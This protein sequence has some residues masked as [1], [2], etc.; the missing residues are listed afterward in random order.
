M[1]REV[2]IQEACEQSARYGRS[3]TDSLECDWKWALENKIDQFI[4]KADGRGKTDPTGEAGTEAVA[5]VKETLREHY[6][7]ILGIYD[8]YASLNADGDVFTIGMNEFNAFLNECELPI[9]GSLDCNKQHLEQL[10]VAIDSGQKAKE[11]FNSKHALS[12]QEFLQFLVRAAVSRYCKPRKKGEEPIHTDVSAALRELLLNQMKP[13]VDPAALQNSNEFRQKFLYVQETD[14]LLAQHE[15]TLQ[16][17]YDVYSDEQHAT[18]DL[19]S[20]SGMLGI[21]QWLNMCDHLQ[22]VDEEFTIREMTSC[23]MWARM[24]VADETN[25]VERRKMCNLKFVDFL[26]ALCRMA[27]MKTMPTDDEV[28][29]AGCADGG[30][31]LLK[32]VP[33]ERRNFVVQRPQNWDS[34]PRQPIWR[35]LFHLISLI[36]RSVEGVVTVKVKGVDPTVKADLRL[37]RAEVKTFKKLGGLAGAEQS[38]PGP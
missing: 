25:I 6:A 15:S 8:Y 12:R 29:A 1:D 22:L 26:E 2:A 32:M 38:S 14:A 27:T 18:S 28:E 21:T 11:K 30:E 24:R 36:T 5:R 9:P 35:C 4:A 34:E 23:F 37:T 33:S 7:M 16:A 13:N 20:I 19:T 17:L 31:M 3:G 10:F